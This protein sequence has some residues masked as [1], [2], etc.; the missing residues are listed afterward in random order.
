ML[1]TLNAKINL[2][3]DVI[4]R[5]AASKTLTRPN[6]SDLQA[7][8]SYDTLRPNNLVASSGNPDLKPYVSTNFDLSLEWYY[9]RGGY[10]TLALFQKTVHDY[11]VT[12]F[13]DEQLPV[14]NSSGDFPN[15]TA[16]FRVKR[17]RNVETAKVK[18]LEV[19]FQHSLNYLPA[20]WD[21]FGFGANAT[22]VDGP[23][24]LSPGDPDTTRSFA[25]EGVGNSQNVMVFYEKGPFGVRASYNHRDDYLQSAFNGEG[26]EPLFVRGS[27]QLDAQAS[28]RIGEHVSVTLEGS[29]ITDTP[30]ETYGRYENQWISHVETGPRYSLG[31]RANF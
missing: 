4:A 9:N 13:A 15:G 17:P 10:A 29:N 22:F 12:M 28:Y 23:S 24:T 20:P 30:F 11:I 16:T 7:K 19:A 6:L 2:T 3:N 14:G 1:P 31:L 21:G 25:L 27:G 18:G 5:V 26:N 8:L